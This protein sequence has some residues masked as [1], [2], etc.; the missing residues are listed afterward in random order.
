[1]NKRTNQSDQICR[2]LHLSCYCFLPL[3]FCVNSSFFLLV[4]ELLSI[5]VDVPE[6]ERRTTLFAS[7]IL[8]CDYSTS[9]NPQEVLVSWKFKSFCKDPVLEYYSTGE[10]AAK[11]SIRSYV[12]S[13]CPGC[14]KA[15]REVWGSFDDLLSIILF[16]YHDDMNSHWKNI[17][18]QTSRSVKKIMQQ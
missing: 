7:V 6:T 18:I 4:P 9:A 14:V 13:V 3:M 8:R 1:M 2:L 5:Q 11:R 12:W 16:I 10:A 17:N 15:G